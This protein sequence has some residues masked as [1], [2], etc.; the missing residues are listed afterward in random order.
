MFI[1]FI[2]E[3]KTSKN[4]F[5]FMKRTLIY[6]HVLTPSYKR[7]SKHCFTRAQTIKVVVQVKQPNVY[8]RSEDFGLC[9][10][11]FIFSTSNLQKKLFKFEKDK[12]NEFCNDKISFC[13]SDIEI[14]KTTLQSPKSPLSNVVS[15]LKTWTTTRVI[16]TRV[17]RFLLCS[18][19]Q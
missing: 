14:I 18:I 12:N 5:Y 17:K 1:L 2:V 4:Y 7:T 9:N 6:P 8:T 15:I 3:I 16:F 10:I 13:S 11:V 19:R